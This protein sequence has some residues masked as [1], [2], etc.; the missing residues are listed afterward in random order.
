MQTE[1]NTIKGDS[2][3][4]PLATGYIMLQPLFFQVLGIHVE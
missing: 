1:G 2:F 3:V 4:P